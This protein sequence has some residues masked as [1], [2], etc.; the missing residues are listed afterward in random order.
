M[1]QEMV[2]LLI[3]AGY[4]KKMTDLGP[5]YILPQKGQ[6]VFLSYH[7]NPKKEP[8]YLS[9]YEEG[10]KKAFHEIFPE[11]KENILY[12]LLVDDEELSEGQ[13]KKIEGI[14]VWIV[15]EQSGK[16][17]MSEGSEASFPNLYQLLKQKAE[18]LQQ[19]LEEER[20]QE[21]EKEDSFVNYV[22]PITLA[23]IAVN[24]GIFLYTNYVNSDWISLGGSRWNA[25]LL[26]HEYYR[27]ATAMF[28][29]SN[30]E[31]IVGNML[32]LF[33]VGNFVERYLGAAKYLALYISCGLVGNLVSFY[34]AI[35][36]NDLG[37]SIGA[38]GAIYGI[39]GFL[40]ITL[41]KNRGRLGD[42]PYSNFF[43]FLFLIAA[44]FH[45]YRIEEVD[46]LAHIGGLIFGGIMAFVLNGKKKNNHKEERAS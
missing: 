46:N 28:L 14:Y 17:F 44:I 39:M 36:T 4:E 33:L 5:C 20:Q 38:S 16:I 22:T 6:F 41:I 24:F 19:Q 35:G 45:S 26:D 34:Q 1:Y 37:V 43:L 30:W 27:L 23:L 25:I 7:T 13:I 10:L 3:E 29:H 2:N 18:T 32:Y 42:V 15:D 8:I 9:D 11:Q 21:I 40:I 12:M 31:H